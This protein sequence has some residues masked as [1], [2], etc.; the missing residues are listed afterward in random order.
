MRGLIET[1]ADALPLSLVDDG[2][3][4]RIGDDGA[5]AEIGATERRATADRAAEEA[6]QRGS[7][8]AVPGEIEL[9]YYDPARDYQAGLQRARMPGAGRRSARIE[10]AASLS[11][12]EAKAIAEA[13]LA[14]HAVEREQ[15]SLSTGWRRMALRPGEVVTLTGE[16][17]RWRVAG[18]TLERMA[19]AL[20][21]VRVRAGAMTPLLSAAPG[22]GSGA[23]DL[24][25]G[26]TTVYLLD[27]PPIEDGAP[28]APRL[29]VA[30][31][32]VSPGWRRASLLMSTDDSARWD[33]VGGTAA[34]AVI[35]VATT[36]LPDADPA[37]FDHAGTV[38]VELLNGAMLLE[39]A[40]DAAL[41][42]GA[43]LALLGE[44]L[45]Q[46]G[47]A[48]PLGD[49]RWRLSRLLRGRRATEGAI[50]THATGERFVLI[51]AATLARLAPPVA[52]MG[53]AVRI[54]A[55]GVGDIAA[56]AE[57]DVPAMS[58]GVRPFA[59]IRL[60]A[61]RIDG[62]YR[63][64]WVRRSRAGWAWNDGG[65]VPMGEGRELYRLTFRRSDGSV[66]IIE[67]DTASCF[68]ADAEV[69]ADVA[70]GGPAV[71]IMV[72][73]IGDHAPSPDTVLALTI[74]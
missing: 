47:H 65:D 14:R 71:E 6:H 13:R 61:G 24:V 66:R 48:E 39:D 73:Q 54:M 58:G 56:P 72:A 46:F 16:A 32:G 8:L 60:T 57:D 23:P 11:A 43:N 59:P 29:F 34:P 26:P 17:G 62:G 27:L 45:I 12:G 44:E 21:L 25:H 15:W 74:G 22:R 30:A 42:G 52:A 1:V 67:T 10:L 33:A 55:S 63:L 9:S 69:A 37:L 20:K 68:Y 70:V 19:L 28:D 36:I 49:A 40:D 5:V 31:A 38:E 53:G 7:A 2:A 4:L 51:E 64:S 3:A 50:D 18:W 41:L 35:G